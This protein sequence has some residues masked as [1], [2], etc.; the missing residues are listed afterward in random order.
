MKQNNNEINYPK[1]LSDTPIN[2]PSEIA[3]TISSKYSLRSIIFPQF[4]SQ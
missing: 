4:P 2:K 3:N 1:Y